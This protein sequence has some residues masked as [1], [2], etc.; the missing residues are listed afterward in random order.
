LRVFAVKWPPSRGGN[1]PDLRLC[2]Y[3]IENSI[4]G[5]LREALVLWQ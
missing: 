3:V 2:Q 4:L 5:L 1:R